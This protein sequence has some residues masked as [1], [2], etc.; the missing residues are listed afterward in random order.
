MG[1]FFSL[2]TDE[3]K[4]VNEAWVSNGHANDL[5]VIAHVGT[6][7]QQEAIELAAHAKLV[8]RAE[9][10]RVC[11]CMCVRVCVCVR[12]CAYVCVCAC[13]CFCSVCATAQVFV[14][15]IMTGKRWQRQDCSG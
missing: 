8:Q 12:V 11:V 2:T 3:R 9:R 7:V 15:L 5:Y 10:E 6:T 13:A 1:E 4:Q 14:C